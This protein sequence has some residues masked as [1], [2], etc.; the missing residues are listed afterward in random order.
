MWVVIPLMLSFEKCQFTYSSLASYAHSV[1]CECVD[2]IRVSRLAHST[3]IISV[4]MGV[5]AAASTDILL[6]CD[7]EMIF[8]DLPEEVLVVCGESQLENVTLETVTQW[9]YG[10]WSQTRL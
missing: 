4:Y 10:W 1:S 3:E 2:R 6:I 9:R 7:T 8:L 5:L